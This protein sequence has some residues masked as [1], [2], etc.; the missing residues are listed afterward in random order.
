MIRNETEYQEAV[1]RIEQE[2]ARFAQYATEWRGQGYSETEVAKLLEPLRS[3]HHQLVEEVEYYQRLKQGRFDAFENLH[4][5]GQLL[6][7]LRIHLGLTQRQLAARLGVNETMVSRDERNEYHGITVE[8]ASK[9]LEA[10]GARIETK[11]IALQSGSNA[12]NVPEAP[13]PDPPIGG[14]ALA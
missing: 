11:V 12:V 10:L 2:R 4:G 9:V 1:K 7:G 3:F 13:E 6:I 14:F 5:L 8:R